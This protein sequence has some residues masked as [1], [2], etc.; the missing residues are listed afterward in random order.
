M[1][2]V[3][4]GHLLAVPVLA[5]TEEV[6][7][8]SSLAIAPWVDLA[9]I[10]GVPGLVAVT[11]W[12]SARRAARKAGPGPGRPAAAT[13]AVRPGGPPTGRAPTKRRARGRGRRPYVTAR[14]ELATRLRLADATVKTHVARILAKLGLR[15]RVQAVIV[16]YETGLVSAGAREEA[17]PSAELA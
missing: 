13:A 10:A 12:A 3:L 8:T 11:A 16:A 9:V 7:G 6:Y 4:A 1:L 17:R 14:A 2:G 5:E 15:N